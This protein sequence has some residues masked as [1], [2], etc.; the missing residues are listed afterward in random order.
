[1][2]TEKLYAQLCCVAYLIDAIQPH[3]TFKQKLKALLSEHP[4]VDVAAMGFPKLW[5]NEP[6]WK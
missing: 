4:I 1:M 5:H 2:L 6:L 3:N